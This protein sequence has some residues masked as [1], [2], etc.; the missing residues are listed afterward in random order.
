MRSCLLDKRRS[1][2]CNQHRLAIFLIFFEQPQHLPTSLGIQI[3]WWIRLP[4]TCLPRLGWFFFYL[5]ESVRP[6]G[7]WVSRKVKYWAD[8]RL[9]MGG[10]RACQSE[11]KQ[12]SL[13]FAEA[14]LQVHLRELASV[15]WSLLSKRRKSWSGSVVDGSLSIGCCNCY[16]PSVFTGSEHGSLLLSAPDSSATW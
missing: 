4:T 8:V 10:C 3:P 2:W 1:S 6:S 9:P 13:Y 16:C 12:R 15:M 7:R 11:P 5:G 14:L